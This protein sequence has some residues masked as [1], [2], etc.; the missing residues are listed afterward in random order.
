M[1]TAEINGITQFYELRGDSTNPPL[2][3]VGGLGGVAAE[4]GPLLELFAQ[5]YWVI[6]PDQRGTGRTTHAPEGYSTRQL[7]SDMAEL[8]SHLGLESVHFVGASTGAAIG[9][10]LTLDHPDMVRTLTM[11]GA[12][13]KFDVFAARENIVR[14]A[15][16]ADLDRT[17]RYNAY[18]MLL[19]SQ[20]F[21]REHPDQ[22]QQWIDDILAVPETSTDRAVLL[23][24][25]DMIGAHDTLDQL[26][27][28]SQPCLVVCGDRD[29]AAGVPLSREIAAAVPDATLVVLPEAG[30]LIERERPVEFHRI[31]CDFVGRHEPR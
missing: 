28:I 11:A 23:K 5:D 4:W 2:L 29:V 21:T 19:F 7:A 8:V 16:V 20:I 1:P 30:H 25:V 24:R 31:V 14:R 26:P 10:H 18:A 13:A 6:A 27:N 9:Q 17:T 3:L 15:L 22:V 12:F